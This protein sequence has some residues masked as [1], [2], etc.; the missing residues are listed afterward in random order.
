MWNWVKPTVAIFTL[1]GISFSWGVVYT[2]LGKDVESNADDIV[3]QAIV[4]KEHS[5]R[6]SNVET[7]QTEMKTDMKYLVKGMEQLTN[8]KKDK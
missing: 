4:T 6:I 2:A 8:T 1:L 7:L 3:T 5:T